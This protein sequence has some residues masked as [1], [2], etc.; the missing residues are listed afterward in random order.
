MKKNIFLEV[1][2]LGTNYFGFQVQNKLSKEITIQEVLER[3]LKKLFKEEIR[4]IYTSR[5]DRGVHAKCQG[6]NFTTHAHIP[7]ANIKKALNSLLPVDIRVKK[8]K[9]KPYDFH[10]RFC[11]ISKVYRYCILNKKEESVFSAPFS[12][13]VKERLAVDL[14]KEAAKKIVGKRDFSVFAKE[15]KSYK[16]CTRTIKSINIKKRGSVITIDI[17]ADG[18][19][20][21]MARN[22]VSFLVEVTLNRVKIS[23]ISAIIS[24]KKKYSNKPAPAQ[25]LCLVK[26]NYR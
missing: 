23:D 13:N 4:I 26:V 14:M 24:G 12:W 17:E 19:L 2:Y 22:V 16:D 7:I 15:A 10:S 8:I 18:F 21:N 3:A 11:V 5:T 25:G 1:E 6:V 9:D 20:R